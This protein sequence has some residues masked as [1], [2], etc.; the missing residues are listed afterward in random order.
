L[1]VDKPLDD[2]QRDIGFEKRHA[3]L[4]QS[5]ANIVLCESTTALQGG[6]GPGQPVTETFEHL[7][8]IRILNRR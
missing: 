1:L 8:E 2:R 7:L 3:N 5:I 6:G 4:A